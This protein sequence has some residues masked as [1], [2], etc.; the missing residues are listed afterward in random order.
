MLFIFGGL[1][2]T[3]KTELSLH[4]ARMLGAVHLRIDTIEQALRNGGVTTI[5][6]RG[7]EIAYG[8]AVDNLSLELS[9]V[10]DSVNPIAL[11]RNA[12]RQV[13]IDAGT[14]FREV[15]V[16]CSNEAEHRKRVESRRPDIPRFTLPT[17]Q[18][19]VHREYA[20]WTEPHIVIDTAG[21]SL[22][23]S[24]RTLEQSLGL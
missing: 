10:A 18:E 11:T 8:V 2:A 16:I 7:Y 19:V 22:E 15:E 13:A 21:Q 3:G 9:V 24:R 17:W 23:E 20:P 12:W 5:G 4:L 14:P 1:P 6:P